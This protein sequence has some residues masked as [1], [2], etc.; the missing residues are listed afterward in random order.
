M[1][2]MT[3]TEVP[4]DTVAVVTGGAGGIGRACARRLGEEHRL[5][6]ADVSAAAL[7]DAASDLEAGG[8]LV[9]TAVCDIS[10]P[11]S[12]AALAEQAGALGP[13]AVLGH[14]AGILFG[15]G[16]DARRI[17]EV[18]LGGTMRLLDAFAAP[19][20]EAGGAAVLVASIA[21]HRRFAREYDPL[22]E[23]VDH[24]A[25]LAA[26]FKAGVAEMTPRG[27]YAVA[28]RGMIVQAELRARD[29]GE[30]G[31]RIT[32]ISPGLIVDTPMGAGSAA[33]V[34]STFAGNSGTRR[35]GN[36][37]DIAAAMAFLAS[38]E[39]SFATGCDLI[40]DGG[41][42]AGANRSFSHPLRAAWH[43]YPTAD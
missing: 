31:A 25:V 38:A 30:R 4:C 28:K 29:W 17:V 37:R 18:N 2:A 16:V 14:A 40:V 15:E 10:D 12:V 27:G 23:D 8:A 34:S 33:G 9:T 21:G 35:D 6:V 20:G 19:L 11:A 42:V 43:A 13:V 1:E 5:L 41:Q 22:L 26:L 3:D 7:E 36:T 24:D 32:T 39:A